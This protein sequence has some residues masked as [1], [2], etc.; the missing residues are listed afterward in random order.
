MGGTAAEEMA[1]ANN[2]TTT[3]DNSELAAV[4]GIERDPTPQTPF[5]FMAEA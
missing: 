3:T 1:R 5:F 4:I 2:K